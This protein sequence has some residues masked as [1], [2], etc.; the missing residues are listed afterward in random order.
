MLNH[1]ECLGF[2]GSLR[3]ALATLS[4]LCSW[5]DSDGANIR[6]GAGSGT[7]HTP[8][9]WT[10]G[11]V[12]GVLDV[13]QFGRSVQLLPQTYTV[14]FNNNA[15]NQALHIE[16]D[17]VT[18]DL[19][20]RVYTVNAADGVLVGLP[21]NFAGRLTVLNGTLAS[22]TKIDV[23]AAA[24]RVGFLT[25]GAGGLVSGAANLNVGKLGTGTLNVQAGGDISLTGA[26]NVGVGTG[27][28]GT[29]NIVGDG[30]IGSATLL[31]GGLNVGNSGN[32][33]VNVQLGGLLQNSGVASIGGGNLFTGVGTGIVNVMNPGS[34]WNSLGLLEVGD[35]GNGEVNVTLGGKLMSV[36]AIVGA[37]VSNAGEVNV[38]GVGSSWENSGTIAIGGLG[39]GTLNI[40]NQ[41]S[42]ET[43]EAVVGSAN[44]PSSNGT[45]NVTGAGSSWLIS[46]LTVGQHGTG[47]LAITDGGT[48]SRNSSS[49]SIIVGAAD[50]STG[51]AT[52]D[53]L[54]S[55][56][57]NASLTVGLSGQGTL[58][59]TNGG[60]VSTANDATLGLNLGSS[61]NVVVSNVGSVWEC[62]S[63]FVVG[64]SGIG[65]MHVLDGAKVKSKRTTIGLSELGE[66]QITIDGVGSTWEYSDSQQSGQDIVALT[67]GGAGS[68]TL[69]ITNGGQ[70]RSVATSGFVL[71]EIGA[72]AT[73]DGLVRVSGDGSLWDANGG[74]LGRIQVGKEGTGTLEILAGGTVEADLL[75]IGNEE[76]SAGL[77]TISGNN[78]LLD[79]SEILNVGGAGGS[80]SLLISEGGR[81]TTRDASVGASLSNP[82]GLATITGTGSRW[83]ISGILFI[84]ADPDPD[85]EFPGGTGT[86]R[87]QSGASVT[88]GS[89][90]LIS[91]GSLLS[92]EGGS[93]STDE[94]LFTEEA[95]SDTEFE[96]TSGALHIGVFDGDLINQ[97]GVLSPNSPDNV[98]FIHGDY[99]QLTAA[100]LHIELEGTA[101]PERLVVFGNAFLGGNL[102]V[103][104]I[105]GFVP[106]P[107]DTIN[108]FQA[109]LNLFSSFANVASGDR[110]TTSDGSGSFVVNYGAGSPF[111][112]NTVV[113]SSFLPVN[114]LPGDFD[115]DGDVDGRDLLIWQRGESPVPLSADD[116]A[117]WQGN[118]GA[119]FAAGAANVP[120]PQSL[121]IFYATALFAIARTV[122]DR[123]LRV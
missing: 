93:L 42:V 9:N 24:N 108:I 117:L 12:P 36:D 4:V 76:D 110:L 45:V 109:S 18:F 79:V 39:N 34:V 100:S 54:G 91:G 86:L 1:R 123:R 73:G 118:F 61:G 113:L 94:L 6:W 37:D 104:L 75:V 115:V 80:G 22:S 71:N 119:P 81:V 35:A 85:F 51:I 31:T 52:V 96:W 83:D 122:F 68:G 64:F 43:S 33:T 46:V 14:T 49:L 53:G 105:D 114:D 30:T 47:T 19:N 101:F 29:A 27:I 84:G 72:N 120:E 3:T 92:L 87:I 40:T 116:F 38:D 41:G 106:S 44:F 15:T 103:S 95:S 65:D 63:V 88:G 77:V 66:G 26:T 57:E 98:A 56:L 58:N 69:E 55:A 16:D 59:V 90:T 21:G 111:N 25:V 32:G 60:N 102:E 99:N 112:P 121:G 2:A 5:A 7:F 20:S 8:A 67:V 23:G 78:S 97:A 11:I 62:S 10:G 28:S 17:Q 70:L 74:T 50:N 13:A 48:V 107:T 82:N 89:V